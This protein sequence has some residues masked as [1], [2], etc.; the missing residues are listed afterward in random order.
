MSKPLWPAVSGA[1]ARD[2]QVEVISNNLANVNTNGFKKDG[3]DFK[4][5]L[6]KSEK[7]NDLGEDIPRSPIK[8]KDLYPLDGRDQSFVIVNG[9][10]TSFKS[11]GMKVTDNPLDLALNGPGFLE[12]STPAGI[13]YTKSGA[14]KLSP[15]GRLV[16][17]EGHPVL[18]SGDAA[19]DPAGRYIQLAGRE[20]AIHINDRGEI[21]AG[22]TLVSPLSLVEFG[23]LKTI[24]KSGGL[25]FENKDPTR[26]PPQSAQATQVKQGMLETSNV[27]PVEEISNLIRANRMFEQD[28]KAMKTVN[29][30]LQRE[31][32][33]VGKL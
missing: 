5:Y 8:D 14:L 15:D 28:L 31:V 21:Y 32:N 33:D 20:G 26:N 16:T 1:V 7:M 17:S 13:R 30:M 19:G 4:E 3:V 10:H 11:G 23:D 29:E 22:D 25:Y 9:T 27:N 2:M 18:A 6:S 12:V 24:R